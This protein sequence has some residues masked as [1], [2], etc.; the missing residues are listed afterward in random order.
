MAG[1]VNGLAIVLFTVDHSGPLFSIRRSDGPFEMSSH[2]FTTI[3]PHLKKGSTN[4]KAGTMLPQSHSLEAQW[5]ERT[6]IDEWAVLAG[7]YTNVI[8]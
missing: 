7:E 6:K 8:Y 5:E 1:V 2:Q 3:L 4:P